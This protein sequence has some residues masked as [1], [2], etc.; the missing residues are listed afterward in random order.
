MLAAL[1]LTVK[2]PEIFGL[3]EIFPLLL[4]MLSPEGS[5]VADQVIVPDPV[6]LSVTL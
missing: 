6:A 1:T 2:A 3:P 4:L 5:P